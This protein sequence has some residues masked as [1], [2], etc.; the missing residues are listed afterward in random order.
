MHLL[1]ADRT[2]MGHL[3]EVVLRKGSVKLY[4]PAD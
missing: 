1:T 2:R 4:L 3:D